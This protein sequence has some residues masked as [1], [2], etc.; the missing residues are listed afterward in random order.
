MNKDI[1]EI[2]NIHTESIK[3]IGSSVY[4]NIRSLETLSRLLKEEHEYTR[5]LEK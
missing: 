4:A 2:L 5:R 3:S 1:I